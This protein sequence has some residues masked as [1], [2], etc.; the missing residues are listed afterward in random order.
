MQKLVLPQLTLCCVD[1]TGRIPSSL[2]AI[3]HSLA[4]IQYGDAI[5]LTLPH[6]LLDQIIPSGLRIIE[7]EPLDSIEAYSHF[8]VKSLGNYINT[9]HCL[10]IQWDGYVIYPLQWRN[11]FLDFD[12]IGA[13][14]V[15]ADG[16]LAVGNGGFS[17]RSK[18]LMNALQ[19]KSVVAQHPEDACICIQNRSILERRGIRF[20][21]LDLARLFSVESGEL[22]TQVFGFH[23]P[24]HLSQL[25]GAV[26]M[27]VFI[28]S[29]SP[30]KLLFS[31]LFDMLLRELTLSA[32]K[33]PA[34]QPALDALVVLIHRALNEFKHAAI[35]TEYSL[36]ICK[37]LIRYGQ[38]AAAVTLLKYRLQTNG[39]NLTDVKMAS[40]LTVYR[41]LKYFSLR[42]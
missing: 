32:R 34:F 13:P 18:K 25:L 6:L 26:E 29:F 24:H 1:T 2:H 35:E 22:S 31:N 41:L 21:P 11:D 20:A 14:W 39:F 3:V 30:E 28:R 40:R 38:Y 27:V 23:G 42:R 12:Y 15:G 37:A 19:D 4:H 7:I 36:V 33:D 16:A 9:S 5:L 8:M 10:V 17:L